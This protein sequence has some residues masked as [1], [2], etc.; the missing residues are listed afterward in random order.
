[1][2]CGVRVWVRAVVPFWAGEIR[3]AGVVSVVEARDA[4]AIVAIGSRVAII[5]G[6]RSARGSIA[7]AVGIVWS[8]CWI[9]GLLRLAE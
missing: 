7:V 8:R 4:V 3:I 5:T 6:C 2:R 9:T 1:M